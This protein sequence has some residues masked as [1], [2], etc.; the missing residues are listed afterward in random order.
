MSALDFDE[1]VISSYG[2]LQAEADGILYRLPAWTNGMGLEIPRFATIGVVH[3]LSAEQ[4]GELLARYEAEDWGRGE[5]GFASYDVGS[6]LV[7]LVDDSTRSPEG[8]SPA[9]EAQGSLGPQTMLLSSE[10]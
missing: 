2:A 7:W 5:C 6:E 9:M 3:A 1:N 10:Y 4:I 8:L